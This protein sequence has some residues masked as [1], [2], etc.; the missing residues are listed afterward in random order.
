MLKGKKGV[1]FGVANRHSLAWH[2]AKEAYAHG[3]ELILGVANERFR[4]KVAPLAA[5]VGAPSE[6]AAQQESDP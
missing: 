4:E 3:A 1:I 6:M 5:E 2:I